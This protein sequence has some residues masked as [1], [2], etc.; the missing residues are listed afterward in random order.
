VG[1][2]VQ[3]FKLKRRAQPLPEAGAKQERTLEA[4]SSLPWLGYSR[5]LSE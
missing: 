2:I 5:A 3:L 4:V 1:L